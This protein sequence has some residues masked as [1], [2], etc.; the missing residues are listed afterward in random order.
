[1]GKQRDLCRCKGAVIAEAAITLFAF[2]VLLL[3]V[4]EAGRIINI[5][6]TL[7][8]AVREGARLAVTPLSQSGELPSEAAITSEVQRFLDASRIQGAQIQIE[9][10]VI[11]P[12]GDTMT[13]VTT[14]VPYQIITLSMFSE[15]QIQLSS[16][17]MMRNETSP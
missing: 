4:I 1:M 8:D 17:A 11:G 3:A 6:Q 10:P 15:T 9:R 12:N 14:T 16:T 2:M 13:R 7:T 5:Q